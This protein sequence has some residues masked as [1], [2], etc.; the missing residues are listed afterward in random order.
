MSAETLPLAINDIHLW[1]ASYDQIND[2]E[3]HRAYWELLNPAE[4][5][6]HPRFHF[7]RD[8]Q[9]YLVTRAL[10]R[11]VLSRYLPIDPKHWRFNNNE[12]GRPSIANAEAENAHLTFNISHTHAL[13][14]LA[15]ARQREVGVDT[16]NVQDREVS[17]DI[18]DHYFSASEVRELR[19]LPPEDQHYRFFEYWTFK[20]SYIKARGMGLSLPLDKFG[21]VCSRPQAVRLNIDPALADAPERWRFWQFRPTPGYLVAL[22]AEHVQSAATNVTVRQITPMVSETL[23]TPQWLRTSP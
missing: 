4:R 14:A 10:V 22:C 12:Y 15:V 11:T 16:E 21:F 2:P 8:R 6:Q 18:A 7:A 20:E 19:D 5:A 17:L 1:L 23:L 13:I 9:R 3:L